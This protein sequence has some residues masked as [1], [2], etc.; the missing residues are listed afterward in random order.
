MQ[1]LR[2][3][4]APGLDRVCDGGLARA[5][6]SSENDEAYVQSLG[7]RRKTSAC[8]RPAVPSPGS[9]RLRGYGGAGYSVPKKPAIAPAPHAVAVLAIKVK[10][11]T[12]SLREP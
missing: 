8:V 9:E 3:I 6:S 1:Y 10:P 11:L 2:K 4:G 12:R 5:G 7:E